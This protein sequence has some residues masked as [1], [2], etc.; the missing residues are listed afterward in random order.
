MMNQKMTQTNPLV[1][2]MRYAKGRSA[3]VF[4][5]LFSLSIDDVVNNLNHAGFNVGSPAHIKQLLI[6]PHVSNILESCASGNA[7]AVIPIVPITASHAVRRMNAL[8]IAFT[9]YL[10]EKD[11][12]VQAEKMSRLRDNIDRLLMTEVCMPSKDLTIFRMKLEALFY[13][14]DAWASGEGGDL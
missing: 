12:Q 13:A 9:R 10:D 7:S 5:F 1:K 3:Q 4:D 2:K 8:R 6:R 14:A 11:V